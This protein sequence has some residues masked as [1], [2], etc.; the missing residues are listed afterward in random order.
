M[1]LPYHIEI[2]EIDTEVTQRPVATYAL[3]GLTV[4]LF[5]LCQSLP[6]KDILRLFHQ[7][8]FIPEEPS[9]VTV[10]TYMFLH[11]G[12]LHIVGNMYFLWLYGRALEIALGSLKFLALY[13]SAG[14]AAVFVHDAFV[15]PV[16]ADI[17][18]IG[19]SGALSGILGGFLA[20]LP[21][22]HVECAL[23][24]GFSPIIIRTKAVFVLGVWIILQ[25]LEQWV[26]K[27]QNTSTVAYGAHIGGFLFG[28]AV[29]GLL[30]VAQKAADEWKGLVREA[31]LQVQAAQSQAGQ[32]Q[33]AAGSGPAES[34]HPF[35]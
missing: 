25:L 24:L 10:L 4:V 29:I 6:G 2:D 17:P 9:F 27:D 28:Y 1:F 16:L 32:R 23:L 11:A 12:W 8:G 34:G 26:G 35:T 21:G 30:R 15:P 19:A 3:I 5:G 20:F 13:L 31:D 22:V 18:C 33:T 14:I 7:F